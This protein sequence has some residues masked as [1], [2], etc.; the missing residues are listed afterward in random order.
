MQDKC[1]KYILL[2]LIMA[3]GAYPI[4]ELTRVIGSA[5][6]YYYPEMGGQFLAEIVIM[7]SLYLAIIPAYLLL[8]EYINIKKAQK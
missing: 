7:W 5:G 4:I 1:M 6:K 2:G 3:L 8:V